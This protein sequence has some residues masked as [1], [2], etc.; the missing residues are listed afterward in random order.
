ML[1]PEPLA[2]NGREG[3]NANVILTAV[4]Y[5]LRWRRALDLL[6]CSFG[7][8]K[9]N[10]IEESQPRR[11]STAAEKVQM[12]EETFEPEGRRS[13]WRPAWRAPDMACTWQVAQDSLTCYRL[14][15]Q[16]LMGMPVKAPRN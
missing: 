4:G 3:D 15:S 6:L 13:W 2:L 1:E 5:N 12:V 10:R 14:T 11:R 16:S 7:C 9:R 8:L